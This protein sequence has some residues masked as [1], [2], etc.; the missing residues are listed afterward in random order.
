M[1]T[2]WILVADASRAQIFAHEKTGEGLSLV[3]EFQHPE[4]RLKASEIASDRAGRQESKGT[5]RGS[6]VE[7]ADP[8]KYEAERF[9]IE[10]AHALEQGRAAGIYQKL[11]LV[12]PAHFIGLLHQ[13][14]SA[15][16]RALV[17]TNIEKD[18]TQLPAVELM[19]SLQKFVTL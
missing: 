15:H 1:G 2:T 8:K 14:L 18:Y 5:G 3:R 9:A 12:A 13:H 11:V 10:L 16:A 19:S 7:R 17:G 4:S 6:M